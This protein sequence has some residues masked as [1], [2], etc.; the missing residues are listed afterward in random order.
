MEDTM[1]AEKT[2]EKGYNPLFADL[3]FEDVIITHEPKTEAVAPAP[4]VVESSAGVLKTDPETASTPTVPALLDDAPVQRDAPSTSETDS[5]VNADAPHAPTL[6]ELFGS[7]SEPGSFLFNLSTCAQRKSATEEKPYRILGTAFHAYV[8]VESEDSVLLIDKHAAHERILFED[9]K[10]IMA[11]QAGTLQLLILPLELPL[12]K[13][14]IAAAIDY[15]EEI[16]AAGFAF[17]ISEEDSILYCTQIPSL[18]TSDRATD[19]LVAMIGAL[20]N[21]TG[22]VDVTRKTYFEEALYQASCKA[23][24]KAGRIDRD[25]DIAWVVARLF[26]NPDILYCPH[27]RPVALVLKKSRIEHYFKRT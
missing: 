9:M 26:E 21:G 4:T 22:S 8:F 3:Q 25:E 14:E 20:A 12:S 19:L 17:E 5:V 24:I 18:L 16:A 13:E 27:G 15:R 1:P 6:T 10:R 23:A 11:E 7:M 2:D